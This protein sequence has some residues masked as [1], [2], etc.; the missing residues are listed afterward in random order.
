MFGYVE[1][2][3]IE[4][5]TLVRENYIEEA[6]KDVNIITNYNDYKMNF[7]NVK[8]DNNKKNIALVSNFI[9]KQN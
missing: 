2:N 7:E 9:I 1:E 5:I 8:K 3:K 6:K 4:T